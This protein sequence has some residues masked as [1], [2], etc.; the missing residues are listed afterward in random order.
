MQPFITFYSPTYRRPQGLARCLESVRQQTLADQ[1]EQIVIPDHVGHGIDGMFRS[2]PKYADAVHGKYVHVLQ[3][4]D[5]LADRDVVEAVRACAIAHDFPPVIIVRVEKGPLHLPIDRPWPP[6][7]GQ[8][9]L[10]C[11]ITLADVW[12]E[13]VGAYGQRYEGD[14][15]YMKALADAGFSAVFCDVV[16]TRG[17]FGGGLAE[18]KEAAAT[19]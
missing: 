19:A 15:D 10:G 2:I 11:V 8:I 13:F 9:D 3:D 5:V 16:F 14:Y 12:R 6:V 7:L 18:R 1:I 17:Q 4:D